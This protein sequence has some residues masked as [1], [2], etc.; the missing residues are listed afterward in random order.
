MKK[1]VLTGGGTMGHISPNLAIIPKIAGIFDEIHYIGSFN[2]PEKEKIENL[3]KS[4][5]NLYYHAISSTKLTRKSI[6]KNLALPFILLKALFQAKKLLKH[7]SPNVVFSKGGYVSVPV[8]IT[9]GRLGIPLVI[10]ESDLSMGLANKIASKYATTICTTFPETAKRFKNGIATGSPVSLSILNA[11]KSH[12]KNK[13]SLNENLKTIAITGGS[14]GSST[15]N[16]AVLKCL[17]ALAKKYNIIHITGKGKK[18]DFAHKN[19]HQVEYSDDIGSI[20][21]ASDLIISRAGSNTIFEIASLKK[22]M[23]LIPL[24]K[25]SSRGDQIENAEYFKK[26]GIAEVLYEEKLDNLESVVE[27][28][29]G[30]INDYRVKHEKLDFKNGLDTL[31]KEI[32]KAQKR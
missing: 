29:M 14:L 1:I 22:P 9:A 2:G 24:S 21:K 20:F 4:H 3:M 19:Y 12:A 18:I 30:Q 32:L 27:K 15:I 16:S 6:F 8:S 13:Y 17:P 31:I 7:I 26:L 23:L 10:H 5:N 25:K 11:D 28:T